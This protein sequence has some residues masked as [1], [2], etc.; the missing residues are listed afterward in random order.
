MPSGRGF[1]AAVAAQLASQ[2]G[3]GVPQV[4]QSHRPSRIAISGQAEGERSCAGARRGRAE[5]K[6]EAVACKMFHRREFEKR[7]ERRDPIVRCSLR[8]P[9]ADPSASPATMPIR[10]DL[11]ETMID[12][13]IAAEQESRREERRYWIITLLVCMLWCVLG[14]VITG[15]GFAL[16]AGPRNGGRADRRRGRGSRRAA[17]CSPCRTPATTG[18]S[19]GWSRRRVRE[20]GSA[21]VSDCRG[22]GS[23]WGGGSGTRR[24]KSRQ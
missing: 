3:H 12:E 23:A 16:R 17:C 24:L 20:C 9:T 5:W 1:A 22:G 6:N 19:A 14:A 2:Q 8:V 21:G 11:Y 7:G 4:G 13:R 15:L 10:R 18:G